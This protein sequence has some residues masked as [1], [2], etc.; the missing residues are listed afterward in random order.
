MTL[1]PALLLA[2]CLALTLGAPAW[3]LLAGPLVLGVPHVLADLR[4]LPWRW[5]TLAAAILLSL[6][7]ARLPWVLLAFAYLHNFVALGAWVY[8]SRDRRRAAAVAAAHLAVCALLLA[9]AFDGLVVGAASGG[10]S[11]EAFA[12]GMAPGLSSV[13]ALRLVLVFAFSQAFHYAVWL[14]L[15]PRERGTAVWGGPPLLLGGAAAATVLVA[16]CGL[17]SPVATRDAY[18]TY[19]SFHGWLEL[20]AL[21][22][23]AR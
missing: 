8:W 15:L 17:R 23:A 12:A 4:L 6:G 1:A 19:A 20:A 18:L 2:G 10:F 9:G 16:L 7:A 3:L 5:T 11:L 21:A 13:V 22:G 14:A